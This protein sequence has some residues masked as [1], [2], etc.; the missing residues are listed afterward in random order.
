MTTILSNITMFKLKYFS[1]LNINIYMQQNMV[2]SLE[3]LWY[4]I[5]RGL[6]TEKASVQYQLK[7][8]VKINHNGLEVLWCNHNGRPWL[9]EAG[10]FVFNL[11]DY[12]E[13]S[14]WQSRAYKIHLF[15]NTRSNRLYL[16]QEA[17]RVSCVMQTPNN[18][19][20]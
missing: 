17:C 10:H 15:N 14:L 12:L 13:I 3:S 1:H 20:Q 16:S 11:Y 7:A 6:F 4:I 18:F 19:L 5:K 8:K 9:Y 2:I